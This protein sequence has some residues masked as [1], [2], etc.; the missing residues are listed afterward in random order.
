MDNQDA[1][2]A[3]NRL[4]FLEISRTSAGPLA[5]Q[6]TGKGMERASP[7]A[8]PLAIHIRNYKTIANLRN[9]AGFPTLLDLSVVSLGLLIICGRN[10]Q[11][12]P[13]SRHVRHERHALVRD[14]YYVFVNSC[15]TPAAPFSRARYWS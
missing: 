2:A 13:R 11:I 7:T 15:T 4:G 9:F 3:Q 12:V 1:E 10:D 6:Y 14:Q 8:N 5:V